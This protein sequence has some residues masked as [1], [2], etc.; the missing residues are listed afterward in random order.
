MRDANG[1][2][3]IMRNRRVILLVYFLAVLIGIGSHICAALPM[4]SAQKAARGRS[5]SGRVF[6]DGRG[7]AQVQVIVSAVRGMSTSVA[8]AMTGLNMTETDDSGAFKFDELPPAGYTI[9]VSLPG[10]VVESGLSDEFGQP[11][12]FWPGDNVTIRM[13]KGGVITGRVTGESG[14]VISG[15]RVS[16]TRLRDPDGHPGRSNSLDIW[17]AMRQWKTDDR[18]IYRIYGLEP[19]IYVISAGGGGFFSFAQEARG[20]YDDD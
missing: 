7:A 12:Q 17:G 10:Y 5:I 18:G 15:I 9:T 14:A 8:A 4:D 13:I 20:A 16:A 3:R 11:A 19:G 2:R 6:A 1:S